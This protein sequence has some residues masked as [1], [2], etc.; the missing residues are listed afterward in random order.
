MKNNILA[1]LSTGFVP[2]T[3]MSRML[4][5]NPDAFDA[6]GFVRE[7]LISA[8]SQMLPALIKYFNLKELNEIVSIIKNKTFF[9]TFEWF[10][11]NL[12]PAKRL[13]ATMKSFTQGEGFDV[14]HLIAGNGWR[15]LDHPSAVIVD[16]GGGYGPVSQALALATI[17]IAFIVP[18]LAGT[19]SKGASLLPHAKRQSQFMKHDLLTEQV[20]K[21]ANVYFFRWVFHNWNDKY[22]VQVLQNLIPTMKKGG[23]VTLYEYALTK[24]PE[25]K[26]SEKL[27]RFISPLLFVF[28][29]YTTDSTTATPSTR[30]PTIKLTL[31]F[32]ILLNALPV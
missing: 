9:S 19:A 3:I 20:A 30:T 14:K 21:E 24:P 4:L 27:G 7:N 6:L 18:D 11:L 32:P 1:E 29:L 22:C 10:A 8:F 12:D 2:H 28:S 31:L 15:S 5:T 23:E 13:G 17:D 26:V 16:G 25:T